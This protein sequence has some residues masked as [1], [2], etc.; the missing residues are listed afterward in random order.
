M[1]SAFLKVK[2]LHASDPLISLSGIVVGGFSNGHAIDFLL[3][4][5]QLLKERPSSVP[6]WE[7]LEG[8]SGH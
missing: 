2:S 3:P 8:S 5:L 1:L 7:L 4:G 6:D